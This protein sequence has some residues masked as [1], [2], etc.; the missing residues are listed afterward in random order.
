MCITFCGD[1]DDGDNDYGDNDY[2][3]N[4]DVDDVA[5]RENR[6]L[7]WH[8]AT[9]GNPLLRIG[10]GLKF[11]KNCKYSHSQSSA[12]SKKWDTNIPYI[13]DTSN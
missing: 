2:V 5:L 6:P 11:A 4:D 8:A 7:A 13:P 1:N 3:D 12:N 10:H 9:Q